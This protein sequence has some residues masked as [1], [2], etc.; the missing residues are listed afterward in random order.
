MKKLTGNGIKILKMFHLLFASMW[1]GGGLSMLLLLITLS[2]QESYEMYMRS[3]ALQKIDDY[4]VIPAAIACLITGL[5]YGIWTNWGFFKHRWITVKWILL[6]I[7]IMISLG[8]FMGPWID[9]NVYPI[10]EISNY[11]MDNKDFFHNIRWSILV[12]AI[13]VSFLFFVYI[14]SVFKLWKKKRSFS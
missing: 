12:G 3:L 7:M 10:T 5:I 2:P 6:I 9:N 1:F 8:L 14:I 4:I 11:T 13:Q